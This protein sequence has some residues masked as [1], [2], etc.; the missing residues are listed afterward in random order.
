MTEE[1]KLRLVVLGGGPGGYAAAF[2]AADRGWSVTLV[3]PEEN[4]G[5][6]CLHRGCIP[7]KALLHLA[8]VM[9]EAEEAAGQG[10]TFGRPEIDLDRV[11]AWKEEVVRKQTGGTGQ[12]ARLRRLRHLRGEGR[13]LGRDRVQVKLAGGD[14]EEVPF[15]RAV[16]ATGSRPAELPFLPFAE[17]RIMDSTD[18]LEL[19]ELPERLLVVGGGYIGLELGQVYAALGSRV[20]LVEMMDRILP[21]AD[22]DLVHY[23]RRNLKKR[24]DA[25]HTGVKIADAGIR[26]N[27]VQVTLEG[28]RG[29]AEK[30]RFDRVLVAVGRRPLTDGL[31]LEEAGVELDHNGFIRVD[32]QRRTSAR[33]IFA[34]GDVAGEPMLAHKAS[35]EARVA[36]EAM[37]GEKAAWDP[38]A[39]PA[40]VFTDPEV[41]WAGLTEEEAR[42]QGRRVRLL[43]FPWAAN[44]RANITAR[45]EG[46][47]KLVVNPGTERL[48]G[49]GIVGAG[50]G[51]L[52]AEGVLAM[53]MG[54]LATDL[55]LAIHPHPTLSETLMEAGDLFGGPSVH[56][57]SRK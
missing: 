14:G 38:R 56:Y 40:V 57:L 22:K 34:I 15:D 46:L 24:F 25:I 30:K 3:D 8:R 32:G 21:G 19:P 45:G 18:A 11:R 29:E 7:S 48:L 49:V 33:G 53:E 37:A 44:G 28:G 54:A 27:G 13:F 17:E 1:K 6:V 26:K 20:T 39:I 50:A 12:L 10:I 31:G 35:A 36:V 43:K 16:I 42:A 41:A 9:A 55:G 47:T 51:E 5:G 52:V 2:L 4:P 23:L